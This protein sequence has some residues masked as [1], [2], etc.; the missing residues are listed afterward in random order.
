MEGDKHDICEFFNHLMRRFGA[1]PF[2]GIWNARV[3]EA[4]RLQNHDDG[5]CEQMILLDVPNSGTW[6]LQA[7]IDM[8]HRQAFLHALVSAPQWLA[9]RLNR[10]Q[11]REPAGP[12][13]KVRAAMDWCTELLLPEF[14]EGLSVHHVRYR[15]CAFAVHI[16]ESV[17]SG[18]YRALLYSAVDGKLH[19]CDDN[20][21][22]ILLN[23][24][25]SVSCDVY[26]VFLARMH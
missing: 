26:A 13:S 23:D 2:H 10:F 15:V 9:L 18:H 16:G 7:S 17:T 1:S 8:W 25:H 21:R 24:F 12:I 14:T 19:Y 20:A 5:A 22:A 11:Q 3:L 4:G 6:H